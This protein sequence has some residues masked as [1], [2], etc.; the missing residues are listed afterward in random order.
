MASRTVKNIPDDL[1]ERPKRAAEMHHRGLNGKLVHCLEGTLKPQT[2]P[3]KCT[4]PPAS[5]RRRPC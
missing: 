3:V 5:V 1:C 4:N 2:L